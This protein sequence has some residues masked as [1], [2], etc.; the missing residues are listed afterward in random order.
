MRIRTL[1]ASGLLAV[2]GVTT[3]ATIALANPAG[4]PPRPPWAGPDGKVDESK[5]PAE[6]PQLGPDGNHIKDSFGNTVMVGTGPDA[7][8]PIE[9]FYDRTGNVAPHWQGR[10]P[11]V[12]YTDRDGKRKVRAAESGSAL[13]RSNN[14]GVEEI[15]EQVVAR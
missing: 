12:T 6:M 8:P 1:V 9:Q 15:E 7:L 13:R 3:A 10:L 14:N 5:L 4:P 2:V 11:A